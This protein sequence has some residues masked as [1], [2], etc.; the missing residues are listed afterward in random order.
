MVVKAES[1]TMASAS[2]VK[3]LMALKAA[4]V[5]VSDGGD[6]AMLLNDNNNRVSH[7]MHVQQETRNKQY[8]RQIFIC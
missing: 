6:V 5:M 2:I 1:V 7:E 3:I 4:R 8:A